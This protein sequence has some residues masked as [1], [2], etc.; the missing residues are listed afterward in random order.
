MA[1][2]ATLS[3]IVVA[4]ILFSISVAKQIEKHDK[5]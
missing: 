1:M 3:A 2:V 5:L 4:G